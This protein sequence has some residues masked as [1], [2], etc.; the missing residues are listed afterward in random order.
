MKPSRA[1]QRL[2]G[3]SS[4]TCWIRDRSA[5]EIMKAVRAEA[6]FLGLDPQFARITT[7]NIPI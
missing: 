2:G 3:R 5:S 1:L 7:G 4:E 6:R